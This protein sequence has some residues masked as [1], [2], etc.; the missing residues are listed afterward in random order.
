MPTTAANRKLVRLLVLVM[1]QINILCWFATH[2]VMRLSETGINAKRS[3]EL[4]V[5]NKH[6]YKKYNN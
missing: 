1:G 3:Y 5:P 6:N 2:T 4:V